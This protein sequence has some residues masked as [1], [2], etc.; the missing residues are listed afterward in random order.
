MVDVRPDVAGEMLP[1]APYKESDRT[2]FDMGI[3]GARDYNELLRTG[4]ARENPGAPI[5]Y[6]GGLVVP[7]EVYG[8]NVGAGD[9]PMAAQQAVASAPVPSGTFQDPMAGWI[10]EGSVPATAP[11]QPTLVSQSSKKGRKKAFGAELTNQ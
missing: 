3:S 4:I 11:T 7:A 1:T 8:T 2:N 10:N 9:V 6:G 5:P